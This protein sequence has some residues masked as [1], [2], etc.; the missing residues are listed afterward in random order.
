MHNELLQS[1][2]LTLAADSNVTLYYKR[3]DRNYVTELFGKEFPAIVNGFFSIH[4]DKGFVVQPHWHPSVNE[5][6]YVICGEVKTTVFNP[7]TQ[8]RMTYCLRPGQ[9]AVFP[10][11]W[12]HWIV[13]VGEHSHFL[14]IFDRPTADVVLGSDFLR[15][16]PPEI[17]NM[18]YC[19]DPAK[20]AEAVSPI[21]ESVILGPPLCCDPSAAQGAWPAAHYP[22]SYPQTGAWGYGYGPGQ[23]VPQH[24]AGAG[25]SGAGYPGIG[26]GMMPMMPG[27]GV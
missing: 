19:I 8:H 15:C 7:F 10:K 24:H 16:T 25:Y 21:T 18:A 1:P 27:A 26:N 11:G 20:Y 22:Q 17:M 9:V 3:D 5:M 4:L 14:T 23:G 12:F 2:D 13:G 6:V